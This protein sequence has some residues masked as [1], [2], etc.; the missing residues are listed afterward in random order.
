MVELIC[1]V[2]AVP[3]LYP[4]AGRGKELRKWA[5]SG[6]HQQCTHGHG[7]ACISTSHILDGA[8]NSTRY[9]EEEAGIL[10]KDEK[11]SLIIEKLDQDKQQNSLKGIQGEDII[12]PRLLGDFPYAPVSLMAKLDKLA[13]ELWAWHINLNPDDE[14]WKRGAAQKKNESERLETWIKNRSSQRLTLQSRSARK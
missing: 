13:K 3:V 2:L 4:M 5:W 10:W 11:V 1:D 9:P 6:M 8:S 12:P 14:V 7:L